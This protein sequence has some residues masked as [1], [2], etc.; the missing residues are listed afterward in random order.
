MAFL[1]KLCSVQKNSKVVRYTRK[2]ESL[3]NSQTDF[4]L[5][6]IHKQRQQL[7]GGGSKMGRKLS[8]D[9]K[10]MREMVPKIKKC[11]RCLWVLVLLVTVK[12]CIVSETNAEFQL[13]QICLKMALFKFP[14][15]F[16]TLKKLQVSQNWGKLKLLQIG[17]SRTGHISFLTTQDRTPK[18]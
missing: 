4:P 8:K 14:H 16:A 13:S 10:Y 9:S 17:L 12:V 18:F 3:D 7:R 11:L 6:A 5:G 1:L 15:D 2:Q